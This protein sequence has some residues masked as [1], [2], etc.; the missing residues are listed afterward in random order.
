MRLM[1]EIDD[2]E[3]GVEALQKQLHDSSSDADSRSGETAQRE[4]RELLERLEQKRSELTRISN[5]CRRPHS[6]V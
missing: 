2:L 3:E 5:A 1:A 6:N 4:L